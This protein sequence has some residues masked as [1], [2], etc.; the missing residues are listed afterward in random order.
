M[1]R[2][3]SEM[4]VTGIFRM[5]RSFAP[6]ARPERVCFEHS[7]PEYH[8]E[9]AR[10][11]EN[12]ECFYQRFTGIAF[13]RALMD[14]VSPHKDTEVHEALRAIAERRILR[15][16]E[17]APF[18]LRVRERLVQLG[19]ARADMNAVA[20]SLGLCARSLRRRLVAE[21]KSYN[22][23]VNEALAIVAKRLL[24]DDRL[25]IQEAAY[26]MGFAD[27]STFHRAFKRW[28]G[29]TPNSF[30]GEQLGN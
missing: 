20:R 3:A 8:A 11:F 21:G 15:L 24:R 5:V 17:R 28:T 30:R 12:T 23:L 14:A 26:E 13:D 27:S 4:L 9:Y 16:T 1:Q 29:M 10:V 7:A 18:A 2:F 6:H 19:P 22:E 25:T